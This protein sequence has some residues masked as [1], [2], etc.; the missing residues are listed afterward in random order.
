MTVLY[1]MMMSLLVISHPTLLG[2]QLGRS[3]MIHCL[4]HCSYHHQA[5]AVTPEEKE[6]LRISAIIAEASQ[7]GSPE[8][9]T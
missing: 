8:R 9:Y 5:I 2:V 7:G 4:W 3:S 1:L 6:S